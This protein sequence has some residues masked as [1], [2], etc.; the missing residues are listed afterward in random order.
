MVSGWRNGLTVLAVSAV[1]PACAPLAD[2][3]APSAPAVP[4]QW[5][6]LV[7]E[8]RAFERRIGFRATDNF[9]GFSAEH[10]SYAFCGYAPQLTLPYSYEDPV[11]H[12][13]D[14]GS[15]EECGSFGTGMN[16]YFGRVEALGESGAA[17]TSA[18]IASRLDR[19]MYLVVHEDC[20]D[21]FDLPYGI[22]EAL[23]NVLAYRTM[24][25]FSDERFGPAAPEDRA[26]HRYVERESKRTRATKHY[27]EELELLYAS[28]ARKAISDMSLLAQQTWILAR[29]G[30]SLAWRGGP[31]NT[32]VLASHMTYSRH[33]PFLESVLEA[34]D[35]DL[36]RAFAFFQ[37]VDRIKPSP[38][39]VMRQHGIASAKSAEFL[40]AYEAAVMDVMR[41]Q[42]ARE[43][44]GPVTR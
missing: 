2:I 28:H 1:L 12:W 4:A 6:G 8:L 11:I 7:E 44:A 14:A 5:S 21:Q 16:V 13:V 15:A 42:L 9:L 19:F 35:H 17:V 39:A 40:R 32:V 43:E 10:R 25:A 22:E 20:H 41:Q 3:F 26:V 31:F 37:R 30:S 23:C 38:A 27:Y 24:I 18:M 36:G 29:A 33:Y 34:H